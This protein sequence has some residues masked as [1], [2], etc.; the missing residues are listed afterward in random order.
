MMERPPS[1]I[2]AIV[3]NGKRPGGSS[4]TRKC[5]GP[6]VTQRSAHDSLAGTSDVTTQPRE[7]QGV[8]TTM[9]LEDR[10]PGIFCKQ[11]S[12]LATLTKLAFPECLPMMYRAIFYVLFIWKLTDS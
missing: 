12:V 6:E 1:G 8:D 7:N 4:V 11:Q 3:P 2:S 10:K 9:Y 5:S